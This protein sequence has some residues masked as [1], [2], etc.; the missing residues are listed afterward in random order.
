MRESIREESDG[1]LK[2]IWKTGRKG[3]HGEEDGALLYPTIQGTG[4]CLR[5][6]SKF[7]CI[8]NHLFFIGFLSQLKKKVNLLFMRICI[9]VSVCQVLHIHAPALPQTDK[10]WDYLEI[11]QQQNFTVLVTLSRQILSTPLGQASIPY[12]CKGNSVLEDC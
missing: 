5:A 4:S 10:Y 3:S 2:R 12:T 7:W 8:L 6:V 9:K 1:A 11:C